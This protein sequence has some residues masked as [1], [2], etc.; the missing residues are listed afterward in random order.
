M[1]RTPSLGLPNTDCHEGFGYP[2]HEPLTTSDME[3]APV[4]QP[5]GPPLPEPVVRNCC[6][7]ILLLQNPVKPYVV[8][9]PERNVAISTLAQESFQGISGI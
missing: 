4:A 6:S 3:G 1:S 8:P 2:A 9:E 5:L 7:P